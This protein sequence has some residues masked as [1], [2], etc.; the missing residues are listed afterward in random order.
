M[1]EKISIG[2]KMEMRSLANFSLSFENVLKTLLFNLMVQQIIENG[3]DRVAPVDSLG[4]ECRRIRE[5]CLK[6]EM[7]L[8]DFFSAEFKAVL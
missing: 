4:S 5:T 6:G 1:R 8:G 7:K 2:L 3:C